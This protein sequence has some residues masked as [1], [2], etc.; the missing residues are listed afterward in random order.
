[1]ILDWHPSLRVVNARLFTLRPP[2]TQPSP[3]PAGRA[4]RTFEGNLFRWMAPVQLASFLRIH[5]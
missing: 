2:A 1:M 3:V 5:Q 4:P